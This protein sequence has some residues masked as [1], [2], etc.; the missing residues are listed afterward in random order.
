MRA[1][2]VVSVAL[3]PAKV[4]ILAAFGALAGFLALICLVMSGGYQ[5]EG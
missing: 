2:D 3:W 4:L 1:Y 5:H